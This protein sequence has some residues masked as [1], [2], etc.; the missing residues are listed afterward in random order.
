MEVILTHENTDFDALA[1]LL[2]ASKL[3]PEAIAVLPHSLNR[4]LRDFLTL[5]RSS[6]PFRRADELPRRP[7]EQAIL[8]DTQQVQ[9][10]R[11]MTHDTPIRVIDHHPR[12][13]EL[14]PTFYYWGEEV[15][16]T[17][18]LLVEQIMSRGIS[19]SPIEATLL[20][21]GIYEDTGSLSYISTTA[22]DMRCAAWLLEHGANLEVVNTFLHH[23]LTPP[24]QRLLKQLQDSAQTLDIGGHTIVVAAADA[25]EQVE[26]I[27]TLAHKLRD[28][29]DP[30]GLFLIVDLHDRIQL[31]ARSTTTFIDVSDIAEDFGGGGHARAAA[32]LIRHQSLTDVQA[33]LLEVLKA[34]VRPPMTVRQ[35]MSWGVST[36]SPDV[37]V[38]EADERMKRLGHEGFP[39]VEDGRLLGLMT[40]RELDRALHHHLYKVPVNYRMRPGNF[41]IGIDDSVQTLQKRM[42]ESGWGQMPVLDEG[43]QMVGIVTRTDLLK[44]WTEREPALTPPSAA[45]RM[46]KSLPS[47]LLDLLRQVGEAAAELG[48][49]LYAVG[50]FVRDLLLHRPNL[51]LDLVVEGEADHLARK[52]AQRFGGRVKGHKRFGTAKWIRDDAAFAAGSLL[53]DGTPA[54]LDFAAARTEFY[55]EATALPIVESSNIKLDLH[56]RDFTINTLAVRLDGPHWGEMLDFYHGQKDLENGVIRV[57]HSLS[58]IEDPTRILRAAR[59]EQ[60]FGFHIDHRTEQLIAEAVDLLARVSGSRLRH[61][62]ELIFQ[63][64]Q[65]ERALRRLD[66]LGVLVNVHPQLGWPHA[67][68]AQFQALRQTK[69]GLADLPADVD[70]LY[71]GLW[72]R[73]CGAEVQRY[74]LDRL[75]VNARTRSLVEEGLRFAALEPE[76]AAPVLSPSQI[77]RILAPFSDAALLIAHHFSDDPVLRQRLDDYIGWI[78][79]VTI[80]LS[81][82]RLKALGVRPGPIYRRILQTV[83]AA[84]LDGRCAT[85]EDEE[86]LALALIAGQKEDS[87]R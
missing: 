24:Q 41:T 77:D 8:V 11:G 70:Q 68:D 47:G 2:A 61:E 7:I 75:R 64:K 32:A 78:R 80:H 36:L 15:G 72:M 51:D 57:L 3:N 66:Q 17:T 26:E 67:L 39:V 25:G 43:G 29:F 54:S 33:R 50:G 44:L 60:R 34:H 16:A 21:L 65:P 79:P 45:L 85:P 23:P 13:R 4:N 46:Q 71:F 27:S 14:S 49:P 55:Q 56:R 6:L 1:S 42:M 40:R 30:D 58:F 38:A 73:H 81:G 59:F 35:I 20:F 28:I 82:D 52:L 86:A 84:R 83:R 22:R 12:E 87:D 9:A 31:I 63:E 74:L 19:L 18:T 62:F 53:A 37:T 48:Y 5:Y 10:V 76:L 69:S